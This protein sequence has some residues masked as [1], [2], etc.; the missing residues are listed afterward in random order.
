MTRREITEMLHEI[1]DAATNL[2][3][4]PEH[5]LT[6][7]NL[8]EEELEKELNEAIDKAEKTLVNAINSRLTLTTK[9]ELFSFESEK[10]WINKAQ[11]LFAACGVPRSRYICLDAAGRVCVS[12]AEFMRATREGTYPVTVYEI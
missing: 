2:A 6:T 1:A 4:Y 8:S 12:G 11:S 5:N 9:R 10:H 7:D 3:L